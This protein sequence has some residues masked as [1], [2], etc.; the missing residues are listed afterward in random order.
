[1][2]RKEQVVPC[3]AIVASERK[4]HAESALTIDPRQSRDIRSPDVGRDVLCEKI[5]HEESKERYRQQRPEADGGVEIVIRIMERIIS[6][7][8]GAD[9]LLVGAT[10]IEQGRLGL[11]FKKLHHLIGRRQVAGD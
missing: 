8:D 10:R 9:F 2:V 11:V 4:Q 7:L 1:M 6:G 5:G 3:K